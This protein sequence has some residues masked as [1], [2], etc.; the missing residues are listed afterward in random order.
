M[1]VRVRR[2]DGDVQH[3]ARNEPAGGQGLAV[4]FARPQRVHPANLNN[5]PPTA[6]HQLKLA[7]VEIR[8]FEAHTY[9]TYYLE[10]TVHMHNMIYY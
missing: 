6:R 8:N 7:S 5:Q 9:G 4:V 10:T 3:V 2:R 1:Q